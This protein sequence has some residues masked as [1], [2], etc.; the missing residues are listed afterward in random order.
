MN[1]LEL[2]LE[3]HDLVIENGDLRL[4]NGESKVARQTLKLNLLFFQGEWFLDLE[5]GVPYFQSILSKG[6]SK[7]LVDSIIKQKILESYRIQSIQTFRSSITN[8]TRYTVDLV[9]ATTTSGEIV[10][11]T[12][13]ILNEDLS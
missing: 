13:Q 1:D 2:G 10:S 4:L 5:Y 8:N 7:E 12:N 9:T 11:I 3:S 6:A